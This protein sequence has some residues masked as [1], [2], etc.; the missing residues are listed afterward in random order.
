MRPTLRNKSAAANRRYATQFVS[1]WFY[2]IIG[3][4]GRAL[5]APVAELAG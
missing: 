1:H 5:A 2:N 4:G 3:F